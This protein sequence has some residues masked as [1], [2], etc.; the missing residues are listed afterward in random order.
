MANKLNVPEWALE[1]LE[2]ING[3]TLMADARGEEPRAAAYAAIR[4]LTD[5]ELV[6]AR[7]E[8]VEGHARKY[9]S[10]TDKG[11]R[12]KAAWKTLKKLLNGEAEGGQE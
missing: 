2:A 10:L 7:A 11:K 9:V 3:E 4:K 12:A 1:Y 5:A 8:L 6:V